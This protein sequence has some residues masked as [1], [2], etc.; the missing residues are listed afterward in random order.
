ML[1]VEPY[2]VELI[3]QLSKLRLPINVATGLQ[4]VNSLIVGTP[5]EWKL[6]AWKEKH[7]VHDVN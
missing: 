7:N 6:R 3:T 5:F 2:D 4:L 1:A